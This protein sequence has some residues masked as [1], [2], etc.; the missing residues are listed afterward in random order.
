VE[1]LTFALKATIACGHE[2]WG[3]VAESG[4]VYTCADM[5]L[6]ILAGMLHD[7]TVVFHTQVGCAGA[8]GLWR[9]LWL[10]LI[11]QNLQL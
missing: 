3:R 5:I 4:L 6:D 7:V 9:V 2:L 11:A 10:F 8:L 1:I